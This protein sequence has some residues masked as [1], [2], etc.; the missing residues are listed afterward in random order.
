MTIIQRLCNKDIFISL[1]IREQLG[2]FYKQL[3]KSNW[4]HDKQA[5][6]KRKLTGHNLE[7]I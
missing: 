5:A 3:Y 4:S 1:T 2:Y 6:D 7:P